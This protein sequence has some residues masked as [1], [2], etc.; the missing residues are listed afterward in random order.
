MYRGQ[1]SEITNA[2]LGLNLL[3]LLVENRLADFHCEVTQAIQFTK[4]LCTCL[5]CFAVPFAVGAFVGRREA[6]AYRHFLHPPGP[7]SRCW[8]LRSGDFSFSPASRF[9]SGLKLRTSTVY[10]VVIGFGCCCPPS[11]KILYFLP[12]LVAG[13]RAHQHWGV[14]CCGLHHLDARCGHQDPHVRQ[15]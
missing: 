4:L 11:H 9:N 10:F 7:A 3:Y 14:C 6:I 12:D 8:I 2:I 13:D 15:P 1:K 5:E